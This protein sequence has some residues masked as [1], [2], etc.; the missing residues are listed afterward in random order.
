MK[1]W[2]YR[3]P[4][5]LDELKSFIET[6]SR[7]ES[8][9]EEPEV[10]I[11][12][13]GFANPETRKQIEGAA[14]DYVIRHL[15]SFGYKWHDRQKDRCGYDVLATRDNEILYIEVKG[16]DSSVPRFFI[17]RRERIFSQGHTNWQ[18]W[19]VCQARSLPKLLRFS[20]SD[21]EQMF[22]FDALAWE[23]TKHGTE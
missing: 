17:T 7:M 6:L 11:S 19:V 8:T 23:C 3:I 10:E 4:M 1:H 18:L 2:D 20:A 13:G 22:D 9:A 14:V 21:M 15:E 5:R 12:G 16:T